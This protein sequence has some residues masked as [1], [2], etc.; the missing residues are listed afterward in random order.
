MLPNPDDANYLDETNTFA[1][2]LMGQ[3]WNEVIGTPDPYQPLSDIGTIY[4][5]PDF[6]II[7]YVAYHQEQTLLFPSPLKMPDPCG[8]GNTPGGGGEE[9]SSD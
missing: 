7:E 8:C 9:D 6:A 5:H 2:W 3:G 4:V 1:D